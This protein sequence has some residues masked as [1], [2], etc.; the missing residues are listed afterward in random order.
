MHIPSPPAA[1]PRAILRPA[2]L[3][4][5]TTLLPV[6]GPARSATDDIPVMKAVDMLARGR[7]AEALPS[8]ERLAREDN[9]LAQ[10][11][12]GVV[13][14]EGNGAPVD[15]ARGMAWLQLARDGYPGSVSRPLAFEKANDLIASVLPGM[16][17]ADLTEADRIAAAFLADWQRRWA[18]DFASAKSLK[19]ASDVR[20]TVAAIASNGLPLMAGCALDPALPD[21]R[22]PQDF[23]ASE[24]CTGSVVVPDALATAAPDK[25]GAPRPLPPS[26]PLGSLIVRAH[27]DSTGFV[28]SSM[29]WRSSGNPDLDRAALESVNRWRL[30]PARLG[31]SNVESLLHVVVSQRNH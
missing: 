26:T 8:L 27:V 5:A 15:R 19:G 16:S 20:G 18:L 10:Y 1:S 31:T 11:A 12:L 22:L 4:I 30:V 14:L 2:I 29:V 24:H 17:G 23:A 13:Y 3:A 7:G 25:G 28:C 21:C 9:A 6:Q